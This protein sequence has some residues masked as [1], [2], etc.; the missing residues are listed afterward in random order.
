VDAVLL[1]GYPGTISALTQRAGR[2]GRKFN[3]SLAVFI[4]SMNPLDQ[5]LARNPQ[6]LLSRNPEEALINPD[7]PLILIEHLQCAAAELPIQKED[8]FGSL[9]NN[10][11]KEYMDYLVD[12]GTLY[13]KNG[14]FFWISDDYP[15]QHV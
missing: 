9:K 1:P 2:A 3:P 15:T 13:K 4:A 6:Y 7:N 14:Q 11:V 5:F 12:S 10:K 8:Q